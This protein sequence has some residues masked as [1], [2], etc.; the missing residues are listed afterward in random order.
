MSFVTAAPATP[1]VCDAWPVQVSSAW[2]ARAVST[3]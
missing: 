3:Q 2:I 1:A